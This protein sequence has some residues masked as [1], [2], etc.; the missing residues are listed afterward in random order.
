MNVFDNNKIYIP[1]H[2]ICS[3]S[4]KS[5]AVFLHSTQITDEDNIYDIAPNSMNEITKKVLNSDKIIWNGPP[6][7]YEDEK[8]QNGTKILIQSIIN[9]DSKIKLAG[10]GS[11]VA[12]I[13]YF[14]A[15][16]FFTH[17]STGGG[18]F[19]RLL[20]GKYMEGIEV[21]KK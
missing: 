10:G 12:A 8:F 16:D 2:L 13:N 18:A 14:K 20:E 11:T 21:L 9:S 19:L 7:I 6:G 4:I 1:E 15:S 17:I 3:K 5:E